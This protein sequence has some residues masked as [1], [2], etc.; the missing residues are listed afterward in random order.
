[1]SGQNSLRL[2]LN[3]QFWWQVL[4]LQGSGAGR[5]VLVQRNCEWLHPPAWM[6]LHLG[7][8]DVQPARAAEMGWLILELCAA[9]ELELGR[10]ARRL[11]LACLP[12]CHSQGCCSLNGC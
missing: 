12:L 11:L 5:A 6:V 7:V 2:D 10:F 9:T 1:M 4:L 8:G 3:P